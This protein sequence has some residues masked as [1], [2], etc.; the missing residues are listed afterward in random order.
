MAKKK[1]AYDRE[2]EAYDKMYEKAEAKYKRQLRKDPEVRPEDFGLSSKMFDTL[3]PDTKS[4]RPSVRQI[5]QRTAELKEFT[6]R[7]YALKKIGTSI[8]G[9]EIKD[10]YMPKNA[11]KMAVERI[12]AENKFKATLSKA[13][14]KGGGYTYARLTKA[15]IVHEK[16]NMYNPN[17]TKSADMAPITFNIIG[18]PTVGYTGSQFSRKY[19]YSPESFKREFGLFG[20]KATSVSD[21]RVQ[22][23]KANWLKGLKTQVSGPFARQIEKLLDD[24]SVD[25]IDFLGLFHLSSAFDFDFIYDEA[26]TV[27][28]KKQEIKSEIEAFRK[29]TKRYQAFRK[30]VSKLE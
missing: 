4:G 30:E 22:N 25:A 7:K 13:I 5:R 8:Q 20:G 12:K 19:D 18:G 21:L 26:L 11:Y 29:D 16:S 24:L 23:L 27:Q 1:S 2:L 9:G 6:D 28:N 10:V 14:E 3:S 17:I 15:G